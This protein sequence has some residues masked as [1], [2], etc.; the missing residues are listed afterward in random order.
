MS[1]QPLAVPKEKLKTPPLS[2]HT[3][4][5]RVLRSLS[6]NVA[7]VNQETRLLAREMLQ[8]MYSCDGIGLAAPQVGVNKR[9]IVID[10]DPEEAANPVWVMVNP[11]IKRVVADLEVGQ[12]GCLSIPNVFAD[13]V[14]PA[15][16]VVSFRDLSGKPQAIEASGLLARVIQHE[17]DH[18][19]GVLFVDRVENQLALAQD[20]TK[21]KFSLRDVQPA[22]VR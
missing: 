21:Q 3:L 7:T 1:L 19:E 11:V 12:E 4:G 16:V 6:K 9:L 10:I 13:V 15:R 14:R 5:D 8:T 17:L 2:I 22:P 18:L 20:L